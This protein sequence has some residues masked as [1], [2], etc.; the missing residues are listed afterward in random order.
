MKPSVGV[1]RV[2]KPED[3]LRVVVSDVKQLAITR[4]IMSERR[5]AKV[6]IP[7]AKST[8]YFGR[9]K[10]RVLTGPELQSKFHARAELYR[11]S[12]RRNRTL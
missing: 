7:A 4:C 3:T 8:T 1:L 5:D 9:P 2:T 12:E 6:Q 11:A 10:G